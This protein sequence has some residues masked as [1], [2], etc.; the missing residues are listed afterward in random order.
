MKERSKDLSPPYARYLSPLVRPFP[1]FDFSFIK[2]V[3]KKAVELLALKPGDSV[4][5]AG[6]GSGGSFPYLVDAV[7]P[8]GRVVGIELSPETCINTRK[9][10]ARNKWDN[11]ELIEAP[12]QEARLNGEFDGLLMFAA[13]DVYESEAA[14]RNIFPH[15]QK[16]ARIVVFGAKFSRRRRGSILNPVLR[17]MMKLSHSSTPQPGYEPCPVLAKYLDGIEVKEYFFGLMF[18]ASGQISK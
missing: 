8:A 4:L 13:P 15:L 1:D 17:M 5:D 18:L 10:I 7:G 3:R 11:V 12:A 14:L 9:R 2:P 16:N 6:C